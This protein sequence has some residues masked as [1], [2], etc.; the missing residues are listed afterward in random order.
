MEGPQAGSRQRQHSTAVRITVI[1]YTTKTKQNKTVK[2][3]I[4]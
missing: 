1:I 2:K 3:D 4:W